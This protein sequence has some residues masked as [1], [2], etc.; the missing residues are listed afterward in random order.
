MAPSATAKDDDAWQVAVS[1][2]PTQGKNKLRHDLGNELAVVTGFTWL[3]LTSLRQLSDKLEG[4]AKAEVQ[5]IISMVERV[6]AGAEAGRE[7]L[8]G[9][10]AASA[11]TELESAPATRHRVLAIDDSLP[12]LALMNKVLSRAG[13]EVETFTDPKAALK[14]F[15][16]TPDAFAAIITDA[17]MPGMTG[18]TLAGHIRAIHSSVPIILCTGEAESPPNSRAHW[19]QA[20][21]RKPYPPR[22]L[23]LLVH[24]VIAEAENDRSHTFVACDTETVPCDDCATAQQFRLVEGTHVHSSAGVERRRIPL[25]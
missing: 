18:E 5:S 8:T 24:G 15:G 11:A 7:L 20:I 19:A 1:S 25:D 14:R 12:L 21:I 22:D 17:M 4:D 23:S 9:H 3:A 13:C 10:A 2:R 16:E 6:K